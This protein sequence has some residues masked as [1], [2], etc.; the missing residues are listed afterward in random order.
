VRRDDE[1]HRSHRAPGGRLP[2]GRQ[3]RQILEQLG[4]PTRAPSLRAPPDQTS[5]LAGDHPREWS[6]E[7]FLDL[8]VRRTQTGDLPIP[9][10]AT[11]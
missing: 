6:Y 1:S 3:V 11:A 2:A 10:P 8:P 4:L 5:G 7:P 9:D